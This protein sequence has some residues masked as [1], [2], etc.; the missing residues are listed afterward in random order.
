MQIMLKASTRLYKQIKSHESNTVDLLIIAIIPGYVGEIRIE[1]SKMA[2]NMYIYI[3]SVKNFSLP[4][5]IQ[6]IVQPWLRAVL[7]LR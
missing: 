2:Q 6:L 5:Q 3:T 1:R 7:T 4:E